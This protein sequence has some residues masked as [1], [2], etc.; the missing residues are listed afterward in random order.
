MGTI[1]M[2]ASTAVCGVVYALT[3][4]QP[5]QLI[6]PM[7]P[8][9]AFSI[10]LAQL[11]HRLTL[12]FLPLYAWTGLWTGGMLLIAALTSASN[13]VKYLTRFSDEIFS[14]L[15]STIFLFEAL[16][17]VA[18]TFATPASSATKALLTLTCTSITFGSATVLRGL[19]NSVFFSK[20][21]RDNLSNFAPAIGVVLG[22]LA[23]RAARMK[24]GAAAA[25]LPALSLPTKFATTNGRPWLIPLMDLPT[26]ARWAAC[27]PAALATVLLFLDQNITARLVNNPRYKMVKGRD[28][29]N[30]LDGMH[31][32]MFVLS[33]L[34]AVSSM[35]GLPWMAGATTRSAAH[36]RSLS[37][38][39]ADGNI[40]G[41]LENRVSGASIHAL[42][43]ASVVFSWP[44]KVLS[45]VPLPVLS[46]VFLYLGFTSLQGLELWDRIQGLFHDTSVAPKTRWSAVPRKVT[47]LLT[48]VQM[49]CV[50]S[51]MWVTKSSFGVVS[52]LMIALLPLL[53][54]GLMRSGL[55]KKEDMQ[56]LDA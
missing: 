10:S 24:Y 37:L 53:R 54:L 26:W 28:E 56:T 29:R 3:A 38:F 51:M 42:I 40:K 45:Q 18:K 41:T 50:A 49:A 32:D 52:P 8:N 47:S 11:A 17:D 30:I 55:V 44:R 4:A 39:D 27:L 9:L 36:V 46:G 19:K 2:V 20:S 43:G 31:G 23:A 14:I 7:G 6:G 5:I 16:S 1:E 34:T 35:F 15:I 13:L 48:T 25:A 33:I 12:P 21:I 22:S